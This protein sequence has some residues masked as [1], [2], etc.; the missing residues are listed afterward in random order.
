MNRYLKNLLIGCLDIPLNVISGGSPY[1]T[2]SER[3]WRWK[4]AGKRKGTVMVAVI[5]GL[6]GAGHCAGSAE[7]T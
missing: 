6:F 1:E 2:L 3:A 5:D 4:V 7:G